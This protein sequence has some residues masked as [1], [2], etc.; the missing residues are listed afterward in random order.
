MRIETKTVVTVVA[1]KMVS[2]SH[3]AIS[4]AANLKCSLEEECGDK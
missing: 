2:Q 3:K 1:L 4:R